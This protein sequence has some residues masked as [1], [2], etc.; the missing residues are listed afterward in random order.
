LLLKVEDDKDTIFMNMFGKN[1]T[2]RK[3]YEE[4]IENLRQ[5]IKNIVRIEMHRIMN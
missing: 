2:N 5:K 1:A 4:Q 3:F